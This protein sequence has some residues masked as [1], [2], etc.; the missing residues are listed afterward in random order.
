MNFLISVQHK[1]SCCSGHS[2][3]AKYNEPLAQFVLSSITLTICK[4][5]TSEDESALQLSITD[6]NK[7]ITLL[8]CSFF[9]GCWVCRRMRE[10]IC[11][12]LRLVL[13]VSTLLT[14]LDQQTAIHIN[15]RSDS[16]AHG[17]KSCKPI[18]SKSTGFRELLSGQEVAQ[19]RLEEIW[20]T[21]RA[22]YNP[23]GTSSG[24][25]QF[26]PSHR[27]KR[28]FTLLWNFW[29]VSFSDLDLF[30]VLPTLHPVVLQG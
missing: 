11:F 5:T 2:R 25:T 19:V 1:Q 22:F 28:D 21:C 3:Y 13:R 24:P 23:D 26:P 30:I 18:S 14:L 8:A 16:L 20:R 4:S 9:Q 27:K 7:P 10:I 29:I 17:Q 15:P 6:E 12:L